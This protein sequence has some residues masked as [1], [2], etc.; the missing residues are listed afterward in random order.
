MNP[1]SSGSI[2]IGDTTWGANGPLD[3]NLPLYG[4]GQYSFAGFGYVFTSSAE[5]M[6]KNGKIYEGKGFPPDRYIPVNLDSVSAGM[7]VQLDS[8]IHYLGYY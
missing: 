4:G 7:D 1:T 6:Y 3:T 5:Y 8:A 2:V